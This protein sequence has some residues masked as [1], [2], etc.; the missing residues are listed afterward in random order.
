MASTLELSIQVADALLLQNIGRVAIDVTVRNVSAERRDFWVQVD[1]ATGEY[2]GYA[3]N[4][5]GYLAWLDESP[6]Q[7]IAEPWQGVALYSSHP[8]PPAAL[9]TLDPNQE[10]TIRFDSGALVYGE[11]GSGEEQ[12]PIS[13]GAWAGEARAGGRVQEIMLVRHAILL[14][15]TGVVEGSNE[16]G[17]F[18][19]YPDGTLW[20]WQVVRASFAGTARLEGTW[21]FPVPFAGPPEVMFTRGRQWSIT[22]SA[23]YIIDPQLAPS[24]IS[25]TEATVEL[26]VTPGENNLNSNSYWD[27]HALAIGEVGV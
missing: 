17:V 8:R 19:L 9:V 12:V 26:L 20:C 3:S 18:R 7:R 6:W 13:I 1:L 14:E 27:L 15:R 21:T 2:E 5:T 16:N 10:A 4:E 23:Y 11:I 22:V 24:A 25:P